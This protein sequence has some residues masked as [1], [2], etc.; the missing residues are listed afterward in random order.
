MFDLLDFFMEAYKNTFRFEGAP[1]HDV[2][3]IAYLM[4]PGMFTMEHVHVGIET[5]GEYTYGATAVDL[6]HVTGREPNVWFA[7]SLQADRLWKLIKEAV[8]SYEQ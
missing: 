2:C 7:G 8:D 4:D 6:L 1:L 5:R 3:T